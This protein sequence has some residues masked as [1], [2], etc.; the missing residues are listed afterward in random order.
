M[1]NLVF[2]HKKITEFILQYGKFKKKLYTVLS[3][4][5]KLKYKIC[6]PLG[7]KFSIYV[8]SDNFVGLKFCQIVATVVAFAQLWFIL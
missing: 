1:D 4:C 7:T 2:V 6:Y 5:D 3:L 8:T